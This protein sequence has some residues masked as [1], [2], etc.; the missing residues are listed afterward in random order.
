MTTYGHIEEWTPAD[1][2]HYRRQGLPKLLKAGAKTIYLANH[3]E[4]NM[5]TW[6]VSNFCVTVD[7]K[8]LESL[9]RRSFASFAG[10]QIPPARPCRCGEY[11]H[12]HP[13]ADLS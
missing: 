2:D 3:F 9:A 8:V 1:L 5:N 4:N 13:D 7:Y 11:R 12:L 6:G 10:M